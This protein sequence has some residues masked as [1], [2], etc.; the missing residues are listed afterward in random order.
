MLLVVCQVVFYAEVSRVGSGSCRGDS[1]QR[2]QCRCCPSCGMEM[3]TASM[4]K[5]V[6]RET[7]RRHWTESLGVWSGGGMYLRSGL[8]APFEQK[9]VAFR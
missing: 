6:E 7:F 1:G 2:S 3:E 9:A 5:E 8:D 4:A